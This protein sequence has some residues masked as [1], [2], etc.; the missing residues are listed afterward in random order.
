M[1]KIL[2]QEMLDQIVQATIK[3][4]YIHGFVMHVRRDERMFTSAGGNLQVSSRFFAASVTK[5]FVTAVLLKLEAAGK[6]ALNDKISAHIPEEIYQGLHVRNGVDRSASIQILHLMSN[7]SGIPDYFDKETSSS[8]IS[9]ND[10]AWGLQPTL[11]AARQKTPKFLPG[12]KA[13]YSDTNYQLLGAII[14][15]AA[16]KPLDAVF[17]E[18]IIH[19]LGM[20]DTYLYQGQ[21]DDRLVGFYY[22]DRPLELP[23][24]AASLGAEGG[25][26]S[27][28]QDLGRFVKSFFEG[29][30]FDR[31][32]LESLYQ[33]RLIF[34]PGV[35][36]YGIGISKQPTSLLN[37]KKGLLG[38]WGQTGAFVFLER[39][40][41][42]YF[43]GTANQFIGQN[44][45]V[46]A[47]L[48]V[49][50]FSIE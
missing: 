18:M 15:A 29:D 28:A 40:R 38:Q 43:S 21:P 47:M 20:Q 45:A 14:E 22:K 7:T 5:L 44:E 11:A 32:R 1:G 2:T 34:A 31:A 50:R 4:K 24:Y 30:L 3:K 39:E 36:F 42:I 8:L 17:N 46:G 27:T 9:N 16:G 37:L 26:I 49:L 6:I 25:I 12:Q 10:Q 33:W 41:G 35:F 23:Q 48:K 13:E 19:P